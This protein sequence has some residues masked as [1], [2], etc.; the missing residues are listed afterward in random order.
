[1]IGITFDTATTN[2]ADSCIND[3][4][5][6]INSYIG[7]RFDLGSSTFQAAANVPPIITT[8][9]EKIAEANIWDGIGRGSVQ[10]VKRGDKLLMNAM[11]T[12]A[13]IRDYE[14]ELFDSSGGKISENSKTNYRVQ[15]NT[16]TYTPTF[17][18]DKPYQWET[19]KDKLDDIYNSR[20]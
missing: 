9:C 1:M 6:I 10:D 16:S 19:D 13:D 15:S 14:L 7:N 12:L 18:E 8:L 5:N 20:D 4:E 17:G 11:K 2:L 3:A